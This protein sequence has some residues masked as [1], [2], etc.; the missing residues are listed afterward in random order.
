MKSFIN[1]ILMLLAISACDIPRVDYIPTQEKVINHYS[2]LL[3]GA[4]EITG[5]YGP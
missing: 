2:S 1:V 4:S 5:I 3:N